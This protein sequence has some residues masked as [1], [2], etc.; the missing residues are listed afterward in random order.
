M[1]KPRLAV[2]MYGTKVAQIE[3][4]RG[5]ALRLRHTNGALDRWPI[6]TTLISCSLPVARTWAQAST[7]LRGLLPEGRHLQVAAAAANVT[8]ADT[9]GLLARFGR[10]VAG[11]MVITRHDEEPDDERWGLKTYSDVELEE[12]IANLNSDNPI[13]HDDS[14]FLIPGLQNKLLLVH[15]PDGG[16]ARPVGGMPSTHIL[17]IEDPR[18]P[19]LIE[20]EVA[21]TQLAQH[22]GL[23]RTNPALKAINSVPCII[24]ERFD[25]AEVDSEVTRLHQEDACQ[26]LGIDHEAANGRGK[27]QGGGG[28]SFAQIAGLLDQQA[29]NPPEQIALL[30]KY[31]VFT[32]VIG[33]ADAHGKNIG[34]LHD[35]T[36]STQLTP[37]YDAVPTVLWPNLRSAPAMTIAAAPTL[38]EVQ[39]EDLE[40]EIFKWPTALKASA[41]AAVTDT[42]DAIE[43]TEVTHER[44]A[45]HVTAALA[46]IG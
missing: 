25:R 20:A 41:L 18:Y 42:I 43:A 17:K 44:L 27:Y 40:A 26:A 11:A 28:P 45:A 9:Y 24:V 23:T 15:S 8:T 4:H 35:D 10:D 34:F 30:A 16:W 13:V 2:W 38:S 29:S 12:A 32:C 1:T 39:R 37:I 7:F 33:N 5:T 14:E 6:N 3:Q 31:M 46:R 22:I 36:G 21:A 19:G